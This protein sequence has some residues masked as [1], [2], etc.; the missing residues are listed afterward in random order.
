M[1]TLPAAGR[2]EGMSRL[3][4]RG[5]HV[6]LAERSV[7]TPDPKVPKRLV[8]PLGRSKEGSDRP[9]LAAIAAAE[10]SG[11]HLHAPE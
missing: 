7:R 9:E 6:E 8:S 3:E 1:I 4:T 10:A 11:E 2:I 5:S